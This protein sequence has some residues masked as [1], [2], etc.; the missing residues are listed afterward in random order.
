MPG[1]RSVTFTSLANA[2]AAASRLEMGV[3]EAFVNRNLTLMSRRLRQGA[4]RSR[5]REP[6][7]ALDDC[8]AGRHRGCFVP[9]P[10]DRATARRGESADAVPPGGGEPN[11]GPGGPSPRMSLAD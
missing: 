4:A 3:P 1:P 6:S 5:R 2:S 8:I 9:G 7:E 10:V 11:A